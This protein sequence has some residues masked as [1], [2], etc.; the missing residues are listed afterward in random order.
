[1]NRLGEF[2]RTN[3]AIPGSHR[4]LPGDGDLILGLTGVPDA[5]AFSPAPRAEPSSKL[6]RT[7]SPIAA[8]GKP[9]VMRHVNIL[10]GT[11]AA[12][13]DA[14]YDGL[15]RLSRRKPAAAR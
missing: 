12:A 2:A 11:T 13:P 1:M 15:M 4:K 14:A 7:V 9:A 6:A 10:R 3:N 5:T 8:I